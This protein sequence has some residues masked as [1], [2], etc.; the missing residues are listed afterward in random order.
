MDWKLFL[1]TFA[2][3]F[4]AELGD[5]TQLATFNFAAGGSSRWVV[6]LGAAAALV[7]SAALAVAAG[8]LVTRWASPKLLTRIAAVAFI[9]IGGWMLWKSGTSQ[10]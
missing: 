3:V 4:I 9:A 1:A 5:K 7:L 6:F 10:A 8:G 2:S